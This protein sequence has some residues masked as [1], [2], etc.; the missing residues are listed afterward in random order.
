MRSTALGYLLL[1]AGCSDASTT[2]PP[3]PAGAVELK[4]TVDEQGYH[5]AEARAPAGKPVR[6]V[7]TRTTD[8]G[9]G[10]Q[11][12]VPNQQIRR[13]LPLKEPVAVDIAMPS[14]GKV[15]FTCGMDMYQGAVVVQ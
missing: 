6:L 13:D 4:I 11:L 9:C 1:L 10:Q 5:P 15:T 7:F 8:E 14:S 2:Q 12:V 3:L